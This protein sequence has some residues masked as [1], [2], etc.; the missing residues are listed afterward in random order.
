MYV[1][2]IIPMI[3]IENLKKCLKFCYKNT[4]Y[5]FQ[6]VNMDIQSRAFELKENNIS[7][8]INDDSI[9]LIQIIYTFLSLVS[10]IGVS[11]SLGFK[12][13]IFM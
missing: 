3:K 12:K 9:M 5:S 8:M 4:E 13:K 10:F 11:Q 2:F 7:K 1:V 6:Y